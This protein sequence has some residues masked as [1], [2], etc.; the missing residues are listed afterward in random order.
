MK[1][2]Y[3]CFIVCKSLI[4]SNTKNTEHDQFSVFKQQKLKKIFSTFAH[5]VAFGSKL[6]EKLRV[7]I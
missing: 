7:T 2:L 4:L 5:R 3:M 6:T 1:C